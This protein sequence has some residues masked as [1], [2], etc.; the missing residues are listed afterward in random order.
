V[1]IESIPSDLSK[2]LV[3]LS[4]SRGESAEVARADSSGTNLIHQSAVLTEHDAFSTH[5]SLR[6]R[7]SSCS[8]KEIPR[9]G[10]FWI[11]FIK[12]VVTEYQLLEP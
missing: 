5:W 9:T 3:S 11:R 8:L 6:S 10:P 7:S 1:G 4:I 2:S 12:W